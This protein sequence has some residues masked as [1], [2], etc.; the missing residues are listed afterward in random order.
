LTL[1]SRPEKSL[2]TVSLSSNGRLVK[3]THRQS[4]LGPGS[5]LRLRGLCTIGH[6]IP[7]TA[8]ERVRSSTCVGIG[9]ATREDNK[10]LVNP[11]EYVK[12]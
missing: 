7:L 10:L 9:E 8:G 2:S 5:T 12:R 3:L 11:Y 6:A 1:E 4:K